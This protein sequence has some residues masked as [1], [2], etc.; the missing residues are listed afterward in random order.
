MGIPLQFNR[1]MS[2]YRSGSSRQRL[3]FD[4]TVAEIELG[5]TFALIA[6]AATD[7]D[8]YTRNR[9]NAH[10]AYSEAGRFLRDM[11]LSE[12]EAQ[13]VSGAMAKLRSALALVDER[14]S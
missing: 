5:Y 7:A 8:K 12:A 10:K 3:R 13:Q 4:Y 14:I 6:L 1:N 2:Q 11:S 9:A